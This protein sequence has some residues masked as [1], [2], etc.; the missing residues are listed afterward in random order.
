MLSVP[1]AEEGLR[2]G[3]GAAHRLTCARSSLGHLVP[4]FLRDD[5]E[6][7]GEFVAH[8]D[9]LGGV[10]L[11]RCSFPCRGVLG[12]GFF[13]PGPFANVALVAQ[14][15]GDVRVVP[16][17]G[18]VRASACCARR[19]DGLSTSPSQPRRFSAGFEK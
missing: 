5:A 19:G 8:P 7:L 12:V 2:S 3:G 6:L 1:V 13:S 4:K 10:V 18:R 14:D 15:R 9:D 11:L 17:S 16:L